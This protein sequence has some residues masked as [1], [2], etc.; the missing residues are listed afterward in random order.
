[1]TPAAPGSFSTT[2][3]C[4][5][6][7]CSRS[8]ATRAITSVM[9]P[10]ANGTSTCTGRSGHAA[11]AALAPSTAASAAVTILRIGV[12][13]GH[14]FGGLDVLDRA[15]PAA[16]GH[17]EYDA[18]GRGVFDLVINIRPGLLAAGEIAATRGR[19]GLVR[20]LD[21]VDPHAEVDEATHVALAFEAGDRLLAEV[22]QRHVHD[23]V[24]H[25]DAALGVAG[26][27]HP[28]RLL[29]KLCRRLRV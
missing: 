1:M 17:V 23:A 9:P 28:E 6:D 10:A 13:S 24:G 2:N 18:L 19:D 15:F 3:G 29:E 4:L 5:N 7:V 8:A 11:W 14:R 12:A 26:P 22:E 27:G 20:L 21:A 16:L 25:V